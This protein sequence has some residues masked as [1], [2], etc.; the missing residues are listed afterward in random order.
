[1]PMNINMKSMMVATKPTST[2][3]LRA[4]EK[5]NG[6]KIELNPKI[7]KIL[8]IFEPTILPT[9]MSALRL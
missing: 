2:S 7:Q 4:G 9:A 6:R 8:K 3:V 5:G 1:M